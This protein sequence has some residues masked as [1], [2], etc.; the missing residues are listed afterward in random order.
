MIVLKSRR[1]GGDLLAFGPDSRMLAAR[2]ETGLQFWRDFSAGKKATVFRDHTSVAILQFTPNGE[3]L[4][5]DGYEGGVLHIP[6]G[7]F[8]PFPATNDYRYCSLTADRKKLIAVQVPADRTKNR[9]ECWPAA[10]PFIGKPL[11][12]VRVKRPFVGRPVVLPD[13]RFL[14]DEEERNA[15]GDSKLYRN[16]LRSGDDGSILSE[17]EP[18]DWFSERD[19]VSPD[20]KWLVGQHTNELR[21]WSLENLAAP[22][23]ERKQEGSKKIFT[24]V[25]FHP[26]GRWLGVTST[27][28]SVK[29]FDT[30]TWQIAR[31]YSW[32]IG[33]MV[34]IAFSPDGALAAT[35]SDRG[36]IVIWDVDN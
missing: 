24:D 10:K 1:Q 8:D 4:F 36:R 19:A 31:T 22:P 12:K 2:S 18:L 9:I 25:A 7:E 26:S 6:S 33:K 14:V 3:S 20:G 34:G 29:L 5:I 13:G 17:T 15:K 16:V 35:G 23:L 11:W 27:D 30:A 28:E 32:G 21:I